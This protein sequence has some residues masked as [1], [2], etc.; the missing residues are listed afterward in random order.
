VATGRCL[1]YGDALTWWPL[2]EALGSSGLFASVSARGHPAFGR[3]AELLDPAGEPVAPEEAIWAVRVVLEALAAERPLVLVVD[4]LHWAAPTFLDLW[5]HLAGSLR[6]A[7]VLLL[8]TARPELLDLRPGWPGAVPLDRLGDAEAADLLHQLVSRAPLQAGADQRILAAAE[9]NPLFVVEFAAMLGDDPA[10]WV[11]VPPTIHALLTA[12]LDSLG[13]DERAVLEAA[14]IEGKVFDRDRALALLDDQE[15]ESFDAALAGLARKRLIERDGTRARVLRFHHQLIRD[16][17]Y[18]AMPKQLRADRHARFAAGLEAREPVSATREEMIGHHRERAVL[19]RR[20]LGEADAATADLAARAAR[21]LGTAARSAAQREDPSSAVALLERATALVASDAGTRSALLPSLGASL[22]EA[23]RIP[24]ATSV[25]D[26]A[27][28]LA[29]DVRARARAGVEREFVRLETES[30]A[31]NARALH[32]A[33]AV[34]PILEHAGDDL[35]QCRAWSLRAQATWLAGHVEAA[36]AAWEQAAACAER[37][38]DERELFW[39]LGCR[40]M[41]AVW[42]PTPVPEAIRRCEG[43]RERVEASPVAVASIDNPL[44]TLHAMN[45]D[46]D[47]AERHLA[48]ARRMREQLGSLGWAVSHFEAM[49]RMLTGQPELAEQHLRVGIETLSGMHDGGLLATA[50]AMHAR[51][52]L[53]LGRLTDAAA[54]CRLAARAGAADDIVTHAIRR[55]VEAQILAVEGESDEAEAVAR[56]AVALLEPT[57][58]LSHRGDAMLD[59]AEVLRARPG[60]PYQAAARDAL[61]EYEH[62]GN[63]VG[64]ARARALNGRHREE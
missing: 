55:G 49:V 12:R 4:D 38:G 40:A 48:A 17:A 34:L 23:G 54:Q 15:R 22:F 58:L 27:V 30:S 39:A 10:A 53:A 61:A 51:A 25:L 7:P 36:D 60:R 43:F 35:G 57:D 28:A 42:G 19:L 6:D 64:A 44:A 62:K 11:S 24:E 14:A 37:A 9:G 1:P 45:G 46:F 26:E 59:F 63:A 13:P 21:S 41:A 50:A 5:E 8:A 31:G 33:E 20:E 18:D 32:V 2:A 47:L 3:V 16:T 56:A 29:P 52:L